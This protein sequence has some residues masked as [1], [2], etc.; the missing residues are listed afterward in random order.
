MATQV[1]LQVAFRD[2]SF[3]AVD[4]GASEVTSSSVDA[5]VDKQIT[6]LDKGPLTA[7]MLASMTL[8]ACVNTLMRFKPHHT[9]KRLAT[10]RMWTGMLFASSFRF[11]L[12]ESVLH[13]YTLEHLFL[14]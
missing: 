6:S 4:I 8:C 11:K 7:G 10:A 3:V 1:V 2:E 12:I 9:G 5:L 14:E 13:D